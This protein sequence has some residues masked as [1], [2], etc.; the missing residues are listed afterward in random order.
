MARFPIVTLASVLFCWM[1]AGSASAIPFTETT[2]AGDEITTAVDVGTDVDSIQGS[3]GPGDFSDVFKLNFATDVNFTAFNLT[4]TTLDLSVIDLLDVNKSRIERC[5]NCFID[6]G[7]T[8]QPFLN[9]NL[10]AGMYFILVRRG[11]IEQ[12]SYSFD[13]TPATS[14]PEPSVL[15]LVGLGLLGIR[16]TRR[17]HS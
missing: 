7:N 8:G 15:T 6:F 17:R 2:D 11:R 12:P 10:Q 5:S 9:V 3:L 1:L 16:L 13:L 4:V 14:V